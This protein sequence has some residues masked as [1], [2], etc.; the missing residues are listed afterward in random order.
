M[1][2]EQKAKAYDEAINRAINHRNHDG[3]TLEQYDTIEVIF[4]ELKESSGKKVRKALI[5]L[6]KI[7]NFNGYT[8][9]NGIDM[10]DVIA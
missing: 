3:L 6:F 5:N 1:T 10:D 9:L 4:P 8:T 2:T 7:E